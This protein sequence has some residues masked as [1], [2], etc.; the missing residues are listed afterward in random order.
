MHKIWVLMEL[1]NYD[2]IQVLT[3]RTWDLHVRINEQI[4]EDRFSFNNHC[5]NHVRYCVVSDT[6]TEEREKMIAIRDSLQQLNNVLLYLQRVRSRQE[7]Q[8]DEALARLKESRKILIERVKKFPKKERKIDVVDEV[9]EFIGDGGSDDFPFYIKWKID[10]KSEHKNVTLRSRC[11]HQISNFIVGFT[12]LGLEFAVIFASI[13][14]SVEL[15]RSR[16]HRVQKGAMDA[17]ILGRSEFLQTLGPDIQLD[18]LSG[19]G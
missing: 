18:V 2:K 14:A 10:E 5:S 3:A 8:R 17:R 16:Q 7:I 13:Y 19:R 6:S 15:C 12:R 9:I 11:L 1:N 4:K